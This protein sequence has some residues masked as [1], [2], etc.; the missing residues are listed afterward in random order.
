M[1]IQKLLDLISF[2]IQLELINTDSKSFSTNGMN[3][4]NVANHSCYRRLYTSL[5]GDYYK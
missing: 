1:K 2:S 5:Q 3:A 4:F